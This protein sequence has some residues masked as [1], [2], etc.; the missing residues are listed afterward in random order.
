[1]RDIYRSIKGYNYRCYYWKRNENEITNNEELIHNKRPDGA[2]YSRIVSN[3]S[4]D[5]QDV[6]GVFRV[7]NEQVQIETP[8]IVL[9]L[10]KD[11]LVQFDGDLWI[12]GRVNVEKIQKQAEFSKKT[13]C[14]TIIELNK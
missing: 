1:M 11:D 2:F 9:D 13:S 12:V 14:K 6:A 7:E 4:K 5:K 10:K 3:Q 8:D